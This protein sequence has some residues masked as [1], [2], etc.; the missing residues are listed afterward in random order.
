[1]CTIQIGAIVGI[2]P[3][4]TKLVYFDLGLRLIEGTT[5]VLFNH[6]I[7]INEILDI[8]GQRIDQIG[9]LSEPPQPL[10]VTRF[11]ILCNKYNH[12]GR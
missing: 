9:S 6:T 4:D 12:L 10:E 8:W 7:W 1:M 5:L 3:D 11:P 2:L